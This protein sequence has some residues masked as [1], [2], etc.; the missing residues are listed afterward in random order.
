MERWGGKRHTKTKL[1]R[2]VKG[3][4]TRLMLL[5]TLAVP[6]LETSALPRA[7]YLRGKRAFVP[8]P[9]GHAAQKVGKLHETPWPT[10]NRGVRVVLART[11]HAPHNVHV[12]HL[13]VL[14]NTSVWTDVEVLEAAIVAAEDEL[15]AQYNDGSNAAVEHVPLRKQQLDM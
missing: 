13:Q 8:E 12:A 15:E 7:H 14:H 3:D 10:L 11:P 1:G 4:S 9:P 5:K 2:A 6:L